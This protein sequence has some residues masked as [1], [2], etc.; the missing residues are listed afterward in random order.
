MSAPKQLDKTFDPAA[1]EARHYDEW[2]KSGIFAAKPQGNAAPFT[3]MM[4]PPNV[5]GSLHMG[6]A[7][8]NAVEDILIRWRRMQG[9][10]TLYLPGAGSYGLWDPWETHYGEVAREMWHELWPDRPLQVRLQPVPAALDD[11]AL[12]ALLERERAGVHRL[13]RLALAKIP[14]LAADRRPAEN[15]PTVT[16]EWV[17]AQYAAAGGA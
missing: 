16:E 14:G 13:A 5:T 7:L 17:T 9:Y 15:D 1:I 4:P 8:T 12:Q 6:H 2:E 11:V 3:M 10:A